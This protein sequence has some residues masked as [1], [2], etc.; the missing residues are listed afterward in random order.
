MLQIKTNPRSSVWANRHPTHRH[1]PHGPV[2]I[3]YVT[4]AAIKTLTSDDRNAI[5][6]II[7]IAQA[8]MHRPLG[9]EEP[10]EVCFT[11]DMDIMGGYV[12]H[13]HQRPIILIDPGLIKSEAVRASHDFHQEVA[14]TLAH[15]IAHAY[16]DRIGILDETDA[17]ENAAETFA[18]IWVETGEVCVPILTPPPIDAFPNPPF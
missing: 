18:K 14:V 10:F 1:T 5:R 3:R 16:Q 9:F 13:T 17:I 11:Q 8:D 15:E 12:Y 6:K 2:E 7:K 4:L